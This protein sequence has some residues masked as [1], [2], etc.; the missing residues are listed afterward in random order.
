ADITPLRESREYRLLFY[1]QVT[2]YLGRQFTVVAVPIQ[3]YAITKSSL[4]VG[5]VGLA[6]LGPLIGFSLAGRALSDAFDRR[7]LLLVPQLLLAGTGTV[8]ALNANAA[9]PA[10]WPLYLFGALSAGFAG[11]DMQTR[12]AMAPRL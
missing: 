7:R 12:N 8:L 10:L 6:S 3:V 11:A 2:S 4:A 9:H 5:L 1:G